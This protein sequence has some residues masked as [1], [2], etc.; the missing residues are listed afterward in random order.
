MKIQVLG[1][2]CVNCKKLKENVK[3]AIE[4]L[5]ISAEI[6]EVTDV[7]KITEMGV[8]TTPGMAIDGVLKASGKGITK[9]QIIDI[10]KKG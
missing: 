7:D 10:I 8:L 2:G 6:E 1:K 3:L 9:E 4:E 5:G